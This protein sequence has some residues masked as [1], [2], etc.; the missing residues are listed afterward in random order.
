[1]AVI[2]PTKLSNIIIYKHRKA[3]HTDNLILLY[4]LYTERRKHPWWR[5]QME[6]FSALLALCAGNSLVTGEFPVQRPVARSFDVFFYLRLNKRLGK[7]SW[8]WWFETPLCS[9]WRHCNVINT[10]LPWVRNGMSII[11]I[12]NT[13]LM[14][15]GTIMIPDKADESEIVE[16]FLR[17]ALLMKD[18]RHAHVLR[19]IGISIDED[20]SP[21]VVLPFMSNGDLRKFIQDPAK[22]CTYPGES[23]NSSPP[24]QNG[25]H[26]ADDIFRSIFV[27]EKFFVYQHFTEVC[28]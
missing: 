19:L 25:R 15:T 10:S 1:M 17:E 11:C 8:G 27:N 23:F 2:Y 18:F 12:L 20:G 4:T 6:T 3:Q 5:H 9:L 21:M 13:N 28:S 26:F 14:L 24:G 22:V 16:L 7:Q